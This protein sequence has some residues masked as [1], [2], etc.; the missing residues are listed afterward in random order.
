[1]KFTY[2]FKCLDTGLTKIGRTQNLNQ[3][4]R[5]L[6]AKRNLIPVF[7]RKGDEEK[8]L[9][10]MLSEY[11]KEGEWFLLSENQLTELIQSS[12]N[13]VSKDESGKVSFPGPAMPPPRQGT[14]NVALGHERFKQISELARK[15][16]ISKGALAKALIF[17][18]LD[19]VQSGDLVFSGPSLESKP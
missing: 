4:F 9:H 12:Q 18:G 7:V 19:K 2:A 14:I 15:H 10:M 16:G 11:R 17:Y 6:S 8:S 13:L 3:R 5:T 1:M